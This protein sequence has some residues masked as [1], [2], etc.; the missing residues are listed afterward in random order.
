MKS[1]NF[2]IPLA[3]LI[4][5]LFAISGNLSAK[6][7]EHLIGPTGLM[8]QV[9]K[10]D[11]KVNSVGAGSPAEGKLKK[12]DVIVGVGGNKFSGDARQQMAAAIDKAEA[13]S[14]DLSLTLKG[15]KQVTLKLQSLGSYS[16]TAP[17][18]CEKTDKIVTQIADQMLE[19]KS[20][21]KGNIP[22][23]FI[24]LLATGEDKYIDAVKRDLPNQPWAKAPDA[25]KLAAL[26]RGDIDMGYI[27]WYWGYQ[28]IALAEYH[29]KTGD[30]SVLPALEAY[31]LT[32]AR[33]QDSAGIWGHRLATEKRNGRLPGYAHINNPSLST[34]IGMQLALKC[35]IKNA[36]IEKG[37]ARSVAFFKTFSGEGA[38]PY[39]VH[40][41]NT[42]I[43]NNNGSSAMAAIVMALADER[44]AA[45]FF[46]QQAAAA[47]DIQETGH[48]TYYFN[49]LWTPLGANVAGPEI[50]QAF[51]K[52]GNWVRTLYR[53]WDDRF[54][55]N[56]K[57]QKACN[58]DGSL[59]LAYCMP[60]KQI[61][62]T[63][64]NADASLW[65]KGDEVEAVVDASQ[66]DYGAL[67]NDELIG[68]FG[69][70]APQVT[71]RAVWTL[72]ERKGDFIPQIVSLIK[73]GS[74]IEKR[75]AIGFFGYKCPPEWAHPQIEL[76][77]KVLRDTTEHPK[78][79]TAASYALCWHGEKALKYYQDMLKMVVAEEPE[80]TF[81][82]IDKE[83]ASSLNI[84]APDPF[85]AGVVT[86][87]KLFYQAALKLADHPRQG[88]RAN[89]L[90]ML[91]SMPKE[92]FHIVADRVKHV[93]IN[94]DPDYHSYH[95]PMASVQAAALILAEL[96]VEEGLEWSWDMLEAK[97]GKAGFK[98]RAILSILKAYGPSALPYL[99]KIE[100]DPNLTRML[101]G[102]RWKG[103]YND[104]EKAVR[105]GDPEE[106]IPFEEARKAKK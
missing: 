65:V 46:S 69:H 105:S 5:A 28:M 40:D 24:G 33:G 95:N 77:G 104:M 68:L 94:Q 67:T 14:G 61:Y 38:L 41:P 96:D 84:L 62:L 35:G 15:N 54:T 49:I 44:E 53:T 31:A 106:L 34:L 13:S 9:S 12:G 4:F 63:G 18:D 99:E 76:I 43:F 48:A 52:R 50:S 17:W 103:M 11:I 26:L 81:A 36:E 51:F 86:D 22:V 37:V 29:L 8:A 60:R 55:Y 88:T 45:A 3:T 59:L 102:G 20:Y 1:H 101:N 97:D 25:E 70:S 90:K 92:D 16:N 85:A 42:R 83:L 57:N 27:G 91:Q 64:K 79:R 89:G 66:I 73:S 71:R 98:A 21:L 2:P 23:G 58:D 100:A 6:T 10:N 30:K 75:S 82:I 7:S 32:M 39:G 78:V 93:A 19:S 80:D 72:R 56:G 47:H 74:E 87:K